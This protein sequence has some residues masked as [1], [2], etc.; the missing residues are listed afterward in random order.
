MARLSTPR[1]QIRL[2]AKK[3]HLVASGRHRM[4]RICHLV[5]RRQGRGPHR[6]T[7]AASIFLT[8]SRTD[9]VRSAPFDL[10]ELQVGVLFGDD[11]D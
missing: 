1:G 2:N 7:G 3:G 6:E 5:L 4:V 11:E 8:A 9:R 10:I